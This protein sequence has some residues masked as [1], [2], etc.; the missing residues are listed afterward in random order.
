M[1]YSLL[2]L[3]C[4][5]VRELCSNKKASLS[6]YQFENISCWSFSFHKI[7]FPVSDS[8]S[9][10]DYLWT[11]IDTSFIEILLPYHSTLVDTMTLT[12]L[13]SFLSKVL[14]KVS[15]FLVDEL[16]DCFMAHK[17]YSITMYHTKPSYDLFRTSFSFEHTNDCSSKFSIL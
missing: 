16:I 1:N 6:I 2:C 3:L 14:G 5:L 10:I 17:I 9:V 7:S 8:F 15:T 4:I 13:V 11:Y 12:I